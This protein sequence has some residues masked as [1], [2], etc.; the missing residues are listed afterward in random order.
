MR[1]LIS[2]YLDLFR[3]FAALGVFLWHEELYN[4]GSRILPHIFFSHKLVI[5]FFVISGYV[6]ASS[7]ERPDRTLVNYSADRLARLSSV[8]IPA[9]LLT[10]GLDAVGSRVSPELYSTLNPQWQSI[11][12]L[13][14]FFYCQQI[15]FLCVNPSSNAPFWSLGYEFWYY[16]LFGTWVFVKAKWTKALLLLAVSLFVGPKILLLLPAWVVGAVAF[17]FS[18]ICRCSYLSSWMFFVATGLAMVTALIFEDQLGL[19]NCKAGLAPLYYSSNFWG[20][21]IFALMVAA[22][23]FFCSLLSQHIKKNIESYRIIKSI[24]WMAGHTFSLYV[25]HLPILLCI[26][27]IAKYDPHNSIAVLSNTILTLLIVA[28]LS[29]ATEEKYP[30]A[31]KV[32]RRWLQLFESK[33]RLVAT[34]WKFIPK[35]QNI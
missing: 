32:F 24:R 20:D 35:P 27:A 6:I 23:F 34:R 22:H 25:Y 4:N 17:H 33:L 29:K 3:F 7:A 18:K 8:V 11:R 1:G 31:R 14:N 15:W 5:I 28:M 13:V 16:V 10:Y 9:L 26:R 30:V 12:L 19:N 2:I 21:N